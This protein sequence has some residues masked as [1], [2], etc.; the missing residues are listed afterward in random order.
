VYRK[1]GGHAFPWV[2]AGPIGTVLTPQFVGPSREPSLPF[3]SSL[4]GAC[5]EVCP[6]KIDLPEMLLQLRSEA[7]KTECRQ[8]RNRMERLAF[9]L[10]AWAMTHPWVY[11]FA[12]RAAGLFAPSENGRWLRSMPSFM[13]IGPIREWTAYRDLPA[14]P[15]H[16]FR[17]LWRR[18]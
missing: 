6:V 18:R 15:P 1:T 9:R 12:G 11:E 10:Y 3:A 14:P 7:K 8:H 2:Y 16:S 5:G 13:N 4:C 17:E